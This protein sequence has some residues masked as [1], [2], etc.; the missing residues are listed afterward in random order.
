MSHYA[1]WLLELSL[2]AVQ[3][4]VNVKNILYYCMV[5]NFVGTY[6]A[7]QVNVQVF[8]VLIFMVSEFGTCALASC[9][10]KS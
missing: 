1:I 9:M 8:A 4:T 3:S 7:K 2:G 6:F 10:A 5:G